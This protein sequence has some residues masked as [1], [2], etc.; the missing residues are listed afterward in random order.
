MFPTTHS[1]HDG[2]VADTHYEE[3]DVPYEPRLSSDKPINPPEVQDDSKRLAAFPRYYQN[4]DT[5]AVG[6]TYNTSTRSDGTVAIYGRAFDTRDAKNGYYWEQISPFVTVT[7][8]SIWP[9]GFL[10]SENPG[11]D[12]AYKSPEESYTRCL[13]LSRPTNP[14]LATTDGQ[15]I[16]A[17][18]YFAQLNEIN[19][20]WH[21]Y[22]CNTPELLE[23]VAAMRRDAWVEQNTKNE[24]KMA[25]EKMRGRRELTDREQQLLRDRNAFAPSLEFFAEDFKT[26]GCVQNVTKLFDNK[27]TGM[28]QMNSDF[29]ELKSPVFRNMTAKR[30]NFLTTFK[31]EAVFSDVMAELFKPSEKAPYGREY[32]NIGLYT[33]RPR[34][35]IN[36]SKRR[37]YM[38]N[39]SVVA[40]HMRIRPGYNR[41]RQCTLYLEP[42]NFYLH[43]RQTSFMDDPLLT[44][45]ELEM[46]TAEA[47]DLPE[48]DTQRGADKIKAEEAKKA[49]VPQPFLTAQRAKQPPG[50]G[51]AP[52]SADKPS[53]AVPDGMAEG[54]DEYDVPPQEEYG[55]PEWGGSGYAGGYDK[56]WKQRPSRPAPYAAGGAAQRGRGGGGSWRGRG[57]FAP[58]GRGN[59]RGGGKDGKEF[60]F[61][62]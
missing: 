21:E 48:Q 28:P 38:T 46:S 11:K 47:F 54:Y 61:R 58:G 35:Q 13:L 53:A 2:T 29:L 6:F 33:I 9:Y 20:M 22:N 56:Q 3:H 60:M 19:R 10:K 50:H 30:R 26:D 32:N 25:E 51:A 49:A 12:Y 17:V 45:P 14:S 44:M 55:G 5:S 59:W 24:R 52:V 43:H 36:W 41:R 16:N 39:G 31:K 15:D 23:L 34:E 37:E 42:V 7:S 40:I 8:C 27:E 1:D 62:N 57:G 4:L 18:R